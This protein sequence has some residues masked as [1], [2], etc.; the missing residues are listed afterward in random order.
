MALHAKIIALVTVL[1]LAA[2]ESEQPTNHSST[3]AV[4]A[5]VA[6]N[7]S[8]TNSIEEPNSNPA[9]QTL[10]IGTEANFPP[11]RYID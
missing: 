10:N 3:S 11:L 1:A 6:V 5:D 7:S 4:P 8:N 9:W 2:C